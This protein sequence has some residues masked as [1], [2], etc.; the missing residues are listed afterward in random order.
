MTFT[1]LTFLLFFPL[2]FFLY[3]RKPD[4]HW[5]NSVLVFASYFFYGWWEIKYLLLIIFS[6]LLNYGIGCGLADE[7][8]EAAVA[9]VIG[10]RRRV[11]DLIGRIG[12][13][14]DRSA[15]GSARP[16][17]NISFQSA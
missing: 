5:Q 6:V 11:R 14:V 16:Q 17:F 3:W 10:V 8:G 2:V 7:L 1:S 15:S 4:Q 12:G 13:S 9:N